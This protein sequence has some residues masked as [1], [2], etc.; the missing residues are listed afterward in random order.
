[1][2]PSLPPVRATP[3]GTDDNGKVRIGYMSPEPV[4]SVRRRRSNIEVSRDPDR[5]GLATLQA[6]NNGWT[7]NTYLRAYMAASDVAGRQVG[8][9]Q[10]LGGDSPL[11]TFFRLIPECRAPQRADRL[12]A[13]TMPTRA[14]RY[15]EAMTSA[16]AF[17]WYVFPPMAFS[18]MWDGSTDVIWT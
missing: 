18:L 9:E 14:F 10:D 17:G 4:G 1:M 16:S 7:R 8:M 5:P 6:R 15:C 2:S 13:G 3:A 11:V 12:A